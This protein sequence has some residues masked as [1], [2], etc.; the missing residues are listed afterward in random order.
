MS[1]PRHAKRGDAPRAVPLP[2]WAATSPGPDDEH[3]A[4]RRRPLH[5]VPDPIRAPEPEEPAAR[6]A[7]GR[8]AR[9]LTVWEEIALGVPE[10]PDF[11]PGELDTDE[12]LEPGFFRWLEFDKA[13]DREPEID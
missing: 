11:L 1:Q 3:A 5:A 2:T 9:K 13:I 10:D 6:S 8:L 12:L 7:D 4:G